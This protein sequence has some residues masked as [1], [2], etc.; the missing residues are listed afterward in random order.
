MRAPVAVR[1]GTSLPAREVGPVTQ[2]HVVRFAGAGGDFNP[3]HHDPEFARSAGFPGVLA[4]GQMHAGM[5][6]AWLTDWAGVEHLREYEVR[7]AAP[8]F[9][10]DTLLFSGEV[11]SVD[12]GL[13]ELQLT[14]TRGEDAVLR[15]RAA[16][17][18]G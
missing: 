7:F 8:V 1:P 10:G 5:L 16:V 14:A 3:L 4:M 15:A 9:L 17:V 6:A 11:R 2:T 18:T 13:A 12:N